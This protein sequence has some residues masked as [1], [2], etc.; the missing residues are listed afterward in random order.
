MKTTYKHNH[1]ALKALLSIVIALVMVVS[2]VPSPAPAYAQNA[3]DANAAAQTN[4]TSGTTGSQQTSE[5]NANTAGEQGK[6]TG[7]GTDDNADASTAEASGASSAGANAANGATAGDAQ[8]ATSAQSDQATAA[9]TDAAAETP[10]SP[11]ARVGSTEYATV[12]EAI[13]GAQAGDT[14]TLLQDVDMTSVGTLTLTDKTLDLNGHAI[15]AKNFTLI[16]QGDNAT[17]RNGDLVG[18]N[19]AAYGL[20]FGDS[21]ESHN[22]LIEDVNVT[23]GIN[24]FNSIGVTLRNVNADA[25][26][27]NSPYYAIWCDVN[28]QATIESGTFTSKGAAVIGLTDKAAGKPD[29]ALA[30]EGG[31]FCTTGSS[32]LV[33]G[34]NRFAPVVSGGTFFTKDVAN[35]LAPDHCVLPA[36]DGCFKV[37]AESS[38]VQLDSDKATVP[39][40]L[41]LVAVDTTPAEEATIDA[42]ANEP[43]IKTELDKAGGTEHLWTANV[44]LR[45]KATLEEAH[46]IETSFVI[47]YPSGIDEANYQDYTFV[48]MHLKTVTAGDSVSQEPEILASDQVVPQADG[49]HI[50]SSLSPFA[51]SYGLTTPSQPAQPGKPD[52]G[53]TTPSDPGTPDTPAVVPGTTTDGS[54]DNSGTNATTG[55]TSGSTSNN[56]SSAATS[57][58]ASATSASSASDANTTTGGAAATQAGASGPTSEEELMV[59]SYGRTHIGH[60]AA[61][62]LTNPFW[63]FETLNE[64]WVALFGAALLA[65]L[66]V[67]IGT[68]ALVRRRKK[69]DADAR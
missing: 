40:S 58:H 69:N 62:F 36:S 43:A 41:E 37:V 8:N 49:L 16:F 26:A 27:T 33:L 52:Q 47:G 54:S 20:F 9:N 67:A 25:S 14:I 30:I 3:S 45:N 63:Y 39:D 68:V 24:I 22:A 11:Q 4:D 31:N 5:P 53:T 57:S 18:L 46:D 2:F 44:I 15:S 32:P 17:I 51:I 61:A 12:A 48:V 35:Y 60:E 21:V 29:S 50:T 7:G 23:G 1:H 34:G 6:S 19:G 10:A 56:A 55:T 42:D 38:T 66:A 13:A 28:A 59:V 64:I 65:I